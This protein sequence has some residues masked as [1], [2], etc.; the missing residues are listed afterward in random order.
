MKY[1]TRRQTGANG[2]LLTTAQGSTPI[3]CPEDLDEP[4]R[5]LG[6]KAQARD[7]VA[8]EPTQLALFEV[9]FHTSQE[10]K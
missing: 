6:M 4:L 7:S 10:S 8:D 2:V 1:I 3:S 9:G 5:L